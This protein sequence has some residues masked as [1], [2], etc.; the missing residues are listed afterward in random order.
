MYCPHCG[1]SSAVK[2]IDWAYCFKE[3]IFNNLTLHQGLLLTIKSLLL[4]PKKMVDDYLSGK[5]ISYTGAFH[6][7]IVILIIK[8]IISLLVGHVHNVEPGTISI[9]GVSSSIDLQSYLKPMIYIFTAICSLGTYLVYKRRKLRLAEHFFLNFY[10][11]GMCFLLALV[12][13]LLTFYKL[14]QYDVF[15]MGIV[16]ISYYIRI[17]YDKKIKVGDFFRGFWCLLLN[18]LVALILLVIGGIIYALQHH[19]LDNAI[20]IT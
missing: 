8:G 16:I 13:N 9:N 15:F 4:H 19:M 1:Q 17:F 14:S 11:M 20:K 12:F 10:V 18:L 7:F 2:R 3:F 5:R 6:F